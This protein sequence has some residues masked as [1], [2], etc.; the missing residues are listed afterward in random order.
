M[1]CC[2]WP[3]VPDPRK[4]EL[5]AKERLFYYNKDQAILHKEMDLV[6]ILNSIK[7]LKTVVN[8]LVKKEIMPASSLAKEPQNFE[9]KYNRNED[10]QESIDADEEDE[11]PS[12]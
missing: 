6:S 4:E 1:L 12:E 8:D 5:N 2:V 3:S 10:L 9:L 7:E 11:E